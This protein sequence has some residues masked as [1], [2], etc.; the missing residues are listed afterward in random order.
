MDITFQHWRHASNSLVMIRPQLQPIWWL[1][2]VPAPAGDKYQRC[3]TITSHLQQDLP[4]FPPRK[5]LPGYRV[6]CAWLMRH[7]NHG[8][9]CGCHV[10][11]WS[12]HIGLVRHLS[13]SH[14][15]TA[16]KSA[17]W[18]TR[19]GS[20]NN[21]TIVVTTRTVQSLYRATHIVRFQHG[22]LPLDGKQHP[23]WIEATA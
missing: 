16:R 21:N 18:P 1:R 4:Y 9:E 22:M 8:R 6:A 23:K 14:A 17:S 11:I 7:N 13:Q 19:W 15:V 12:L 3:H 2:A 5:S 20:A 10:T